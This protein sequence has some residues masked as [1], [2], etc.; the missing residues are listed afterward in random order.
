[1]NNKTV[2]MIWLNSRV[3]KKIKLISELTNKVREVK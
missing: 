3:N 2:Q 1:M